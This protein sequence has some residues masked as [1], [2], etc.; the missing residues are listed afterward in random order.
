VLH[1]TGSGE[2]I[3]C[4]DLTDNWLAFRSGSFK[5]TETGTALYGSITGR[6]HL[7]ISSD[8]ESQVK[9]YVSGLKPSQSYGSHVHN[10]ACESG[11]GGH[12]LDDTAGKDEAA[13][14]LFP[15]FKT[16]SD[17]VGRG[18]AKNKFIVRPDARS[19]VIHE[20]GTGERIACA[21]LN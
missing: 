3:A 15:L 2:K 11:G 20:P 4:A 12:Y 8:G 6:A 9:L 19:V 18:D 14:G 21:D 7:K 10:G 17:G 1:Q 5:T 16:N 13:N